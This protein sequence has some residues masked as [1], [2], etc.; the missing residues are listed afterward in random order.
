MNK[1]LA[2][3]GVAFGLAGRR[4]RR[5]R[6]R[7]AQHLRCGDHGT[8]ATAAADSTARPTRFRH[9]HA[10]GPTRPSV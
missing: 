4:R 10:T 2:T 3:L 1:K 8:T 9:R 7:A 6:L 5:P